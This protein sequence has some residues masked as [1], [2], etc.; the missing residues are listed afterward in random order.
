VNRDEILAE[1]TRLISGERDREYGS[2]AENFQ[3]IADLWLITFGWDATPPKVALAML[4]VKAARLAPNQ[5][6]RDSWIDIAG[7]AAIGGELTS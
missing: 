5:T 1:A 6:H 7:Y 2:P 4:L 3:R